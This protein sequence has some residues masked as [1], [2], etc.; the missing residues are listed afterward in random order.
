MSYKLCIDLCSGLGG[1]SAAFRDAGWEV[2][3]VDIDPKF[4]PT[5]CRDITKLSIEELE[6]YLPSPLRLHWNPFVVLASPPCER[7]SVASHAWPKVGIQKALEM[8]GACLEI[9]AKMKPDKWLLENPMGRLRWILGSP[10]MTLRLSDFGSQY[11]KLT[12][13]WGNIPIPMV[14]GM[15][16]HTAYVANRMPG[17]NRLPRPTNDASKKAL[18]PYGLSQAVLEAVSM[19]PQA[20]P[21]SMEAGT[22]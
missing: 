6:S 21:K 15:R 4:K 1:F 2:V 3:T 5:I 11:R 19:D 14:E 17:F 13:F 7:F 10:S 18:M 20:Q 12:D 8:V 16:Q 9:V 22:K